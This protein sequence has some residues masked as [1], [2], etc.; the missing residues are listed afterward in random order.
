MFLINLRLNLPFT[1]LVQCIALP[2]R[3]LLS[4][5]LE[6]LNFIVEPITKQNVYSLYFEY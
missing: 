2:Y 3:I 4:P 5:V 6:Q 1:A